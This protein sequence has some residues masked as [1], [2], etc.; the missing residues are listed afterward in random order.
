[1]KNCHLEIRRTITWM[2]IQMGIDPLS[3]MRF[4]DPDTSAGQIAALQAAWREARAARESGKGERCA[5][6]S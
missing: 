2:A 4:V 5:S 3:A 1:M 6:L